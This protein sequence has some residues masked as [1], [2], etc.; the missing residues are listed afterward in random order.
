MKLRNGKK[1]EY[2]RWS[3]AV[4]LSQL[5]ASRAL[6]TPIIYHSCSTFPN[7]CTSS[8]LQNNYLAN[9]NNH[10]HHH[11]TPYLLLPK[12]SRRNPHFISGLK[13]NFIRHHP[14]SHIY[15]QYQNHYVV[16]LSLKTQSLQQQSIFL[17]SL[18]HF[19]KK[20]QIKSR[21]MNLD[22]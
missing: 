12:P 10:S 21:P 1:Y 3:R 16:P 9:Y 14:Y 2:F 22:L 13:T 6:L 7:Q 15:P 11:N 8:L 17:S 20:N 19:L 4:Y 18:A 5:K